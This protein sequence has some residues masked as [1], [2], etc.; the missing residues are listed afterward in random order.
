MTNETENQPHCEHKPSEIILPD[1]CGIESVP[2]AF[3]DTIVIRCDSPRTLHWLD[4]SVLEMRK[5]DKITL[6]VICPCCGK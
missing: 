3:G 2:L 1:S 6:V 4:G 5:G